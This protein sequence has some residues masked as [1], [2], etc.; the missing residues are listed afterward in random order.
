LSRAEVAKLFFAEV[1]AEI[2]RFCAEKTFGWCIILVV[3][4]FVQLR[5]A[6]WPGGL[7]MSLPGDAEIALRLSPSDSA[8]HD[9]GGARGP[10]EEQVLALFEELR[11]PLLRYLLSLRLA[12]Q[13]SE[14]ILQ[15]TFLKLFE[16]L[17]SSRPDSNIR[18]W[19][20]R[21][22]HNLAL[23]ELR[24][25]RHDAASAASVLD[26]PIGP[27]EDPHP[28][29]EQQLILNQREARLLA[30]L[31]QLPAI[32]Q[33]CMHLRAEGLRYRE[34]AN[35]LHISVTT[36]ADSLRRAIDAIRKEVHG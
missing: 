28:D 26:L 18:G 19:L 21:V 32:E 10:I 5:G 8:T 1:L 34:I 6:G 25:R 36:V 9:S 11:E 16:H 35:V 27:Q 15:D 22:A 20:F 3:L 23:Q 4:R 24:G 30:A 12:P 31:E 2:L 14:E 29:P 13:R 17:K 33:R 7:M